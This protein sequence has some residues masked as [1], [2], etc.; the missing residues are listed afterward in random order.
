MILQI[1]KDRSGSSRGTMRIPTRPR[2]KSNWAD[3]SAAETRTLASSAAATRR[4]ARTCV[5]SC[6]ATLMAIAS[7]EPASALWT[8][9][10]PPLHALALGAAEHV[11]GRQPGY[12]SGHVRPERDAPRQV[13]VGRERR[14]A[15]AAQ[16]LQQEP[17]PEKDDRRHFD[18][19][20]EHEDRD[21]RHDARP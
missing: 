16:K 3:T 6:G 5:G 19:L 4:R 2:P 21:Q 11:H 9:V 13:G 14:C 20:D 10:V 15:Q 12:E 7:I 18:E 17:Q 8:P 1:V